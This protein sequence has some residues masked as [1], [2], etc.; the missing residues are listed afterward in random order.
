MNTF[1]YVSA[2][3]LSDALS[4]DSINRQWLAGGTDLLTLLKHNLY[5]PRHLVD[6]KRISA[7]DGD[8]RPT[9]QGVSIG[10]LTTLTTLASDSLI[11]QRYPALAEAAGSA[12][13]VQ[14][15][16]RATLAGNLLQRP[17]C[18]YFRNPDI[19]CW[20]KDGT[21]CPAETGHNS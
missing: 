12:A 3:T 21:D 5:K 2:K 8:V 16:N 9:E 17:R 20:L 1:D 19:Q 7:L 6:I 11:C 13:T 14:I 18:G 10:A 4:T 15:R